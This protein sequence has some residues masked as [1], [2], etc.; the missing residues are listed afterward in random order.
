VNHRD[1]F[2]KTLSFKEGVVSDVIVNTEAGELS[3]VATEPIELKGSIEGMLI[4]TIK[5]DAIKNVVNEIKI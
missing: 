2:K 4:T 1:Y 3:V 5:F